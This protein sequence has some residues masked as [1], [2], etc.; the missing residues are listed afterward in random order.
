MI[1]FYNRSGTYIHVYVQRHPVMEAAMFAM[2]AA[3]ALT[4]APRYAC[5]DYSKLLSLC[6]SA[7]LVFDLPKLSHNT[8]FTSLAPCCGS[9][10]D[11]DSGADPQG[12]VLVGIQT[13]Y[14]A[15]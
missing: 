13:E 9:H 6:A 14:S 5:L 7:C 12:S 2:E 4:Q 15:V 11:Q 8:P 10:P 3:Q 1:F